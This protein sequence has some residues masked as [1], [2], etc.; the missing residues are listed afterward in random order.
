MSHYQV[1]LD[2][3]HVSTPQETEICPVPYRENTTFEEKF[4]QTRLA[5]LRAKSM[6]DRTLQLAY[7]FYLGQLLEIHATGTQRTQ[8]SLRLTAHYR[9]VTRRMYYLFEFLGIPQI[10]RTTRMTLTNVQMLTSKEYKT[11]V[12]ESLNIFQQS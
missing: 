8:Y 6:N 7:A 11:L 3:L 9:N 1:V 12:F 10:M 5:I 2:D 4:E